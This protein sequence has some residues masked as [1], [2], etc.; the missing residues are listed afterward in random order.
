QSNLPKVAKVG[1]MASMSGLIDQGAV[2]TF[3]ITD[4]KGGIVLKNVT[5][6]T[7]PGFG[8]FEVRGEGGTILD[9][10]RIV[11]G[12]KPE[13]AT[14]ERLL[15]TI[16]DAIHHKLTH[17]GP[18]VQNCVIQD[19]GDDSWSVTWDG[20]YE[21]VSVV[22]NK[23]TAVVKESGKDAVEVLQ[24]GDSL[25]TSLS[26]Q[27]VKIIDIT[28][29]VLTLDKQCPWTV[30]TRFYSPYRRCEHFVFSN[31]YLHSSGRVLVKSGHGL[32][33]NNFLDNTGK[34]VVNT[35]I[36]DGATG[37]DSLVIRK[38]LIVGVG[39]FMPASWSSQAGAIS[40]TDVLSNEIHPVGSFRNFVIENNTFKDVSG[41]NIVVTSS[42]NINIKENKFYQTGIS[43]PNNTG[44]SYGIDQNTVVYI[45]NCDNLTMDYN[46]VYQLGLTA[47]LK[48]WFVTN[49]VQLRRAIFVDESINDLSSDLYIKAVG[50]NDAVFHVSGDTIYNKYIEGNMYNKIDFGK[51]NNITITP[52]KEGYEFIPVS[53]NFSKASGINL[54]SFTLKLNSAPNAIEKTDA[55]NTKI[56]T[57]KKGI[58]VELDHAPSSI[59][60]YNPI[61]ILVHKFQTWQT[62]NVIPIDK[63]GL[64]IV[65]VDN[66][67]KSNI[68]KVMITH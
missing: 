40:I 10:C 22:G 36:V 1:D 24:I 9:G 2:H 32:I 38:N 28:N 19:A 30:N 65:K 48:L 47:R 56:F 59:A 31:N 23:I 66:R 41:V 26:S 51:K 37:I 11:K 29:G 44:E 46:I 6:N 63:S 55:N 50:V 42:S 33:E 3:A 12:A 60:I 49:F 7:G 16:W 34:I 64:F 27:A 62:S 21:I 5:I 52:Q 68:A 43:T 53:Q 35:E 20:D 25:R 57:S 14:E 54:F 15:T 45:K 58:V 17:R 8:I 39:H 18:I 4:C 61:G 67:G 13:G